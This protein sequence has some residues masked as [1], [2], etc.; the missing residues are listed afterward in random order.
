[1][2][3]IWNSGRLDRC[4]HLQT[5]YL[6]APRHRDI[7]ENKHEYMVVTAVFLNCFWF[8]YSKYFN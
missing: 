8:L 7:V 6:V 3:R 4:S 2:E 5:Q 1:M